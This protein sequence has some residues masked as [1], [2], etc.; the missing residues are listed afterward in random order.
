MDER[1]IYGC[2]NEKMDTESFEEHSIHQMIDMAR[3]DMLSGCFQVLPC[4]KRAVLNLWVA[5][6]LATVYLQTYSHYNINSKI[7]VMN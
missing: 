7:I 6:P 1:S 5:M 2:L 3:S 4:S